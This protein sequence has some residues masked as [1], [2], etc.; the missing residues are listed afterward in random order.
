VHS[1]LYLQFNYELQEAHQGIRVAQQDME[2]AQR[3]IK[4]T[5]RDLEATRREF[6]SQLTAG[7]ACTTQ[8]KRRF[9]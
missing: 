1:G 5:R 6:E 2:V 8:G 7:G 3:D 4:I 9:Q